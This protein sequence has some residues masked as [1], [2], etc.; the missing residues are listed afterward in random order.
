MMP[1]RSPFVA[2][3]VV[4]ALGVGASAADAQQPILPGGVPVGGVAQNG[5]SAAG[6]CGQSVGSFQ[7][8]GRAGGIDAFTCQGAGLSFVGPAVGQV[9]SVVGPT[10]MSPGFIGTTIV[11][12][13]NVGI[14]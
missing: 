11:T 10:I 6:P 8:M 2:A 9:S 1:R 3:L 12:S 13:G 5:Q 14:P 7:G 4:A